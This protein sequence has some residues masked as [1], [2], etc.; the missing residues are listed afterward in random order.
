ME[1]NTSKHLTISTIKY[2]LTISKLHLFVKTELLIRNIFKWHN[3]S[4]LLRQIGV[5]YFE[6]NPAGLALRGTVFFHL[7]P[8]LIE[9]PILENACQYICLKY[10][11]GVTLHKSILVIFFRFRDSKCSQQTNTLRI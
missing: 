2:S 11:L 8:F 9:L 3:Q 6:F 5:G 4:S 1:F 10:C 7:Y